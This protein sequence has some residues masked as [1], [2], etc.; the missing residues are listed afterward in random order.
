MM[1]QDG[2]R[3]GFRIVGGLFNERRLVDSDAAFE[4]HA[5][6]YPDPNKDLHRECYLSAFRFA[7][8]FA[9]HLTDLGSPKG[10]S[11]PTWAAWLWFDIDRDELDK[12]TN[13][14][15]QLANTLIDRFALV[16]D[17]L[18]IFYSGS[19]GFHIGL[20][21]AIY[22][23]MPAERFHSYCRRFAENVGEL[24]DVQIDTGVYDRIRAFRAPNSKHQKTG[25]FKRYLPFDDFMVLTAS[26]IVD[27]AST[28]KAFALPVIPGACRQG[29]N[30]WQ[31]ARD[32]VDF[33]AIAAT[34]HPRQPR[35]DGF[36]GSQFATLNRSTWEFMHDGAT[37]GDRHRRLFSAAANLG[38]VGCSFELAWALL[39][40]SALD[41][42]LSPSDLRRQIDCGLNHTG[43]RQ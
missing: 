5:R 26:E 24:A 17:D 10:F 27:L 21:T 32:A 28:P 22:S 37:S 41:S 11:G 40:E 1:A 35:S 20:P 2:F 8:D 18:L 33:E 25:R 31:I 3:F 16:G 43:G 7:D 29:L 13:D 39:N 34:K 23:A 6:C 42:G 19:K 12:A 9:K 36:T 14:A 4:A 38:E 30:D 15:R